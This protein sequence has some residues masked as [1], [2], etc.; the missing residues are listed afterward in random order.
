ML[1]LGLADA[2]HDAAVRSRSRLVGA[3]GLHQ[4]QQAR[5]IAEREVETDTQRLLRLR[6]AQYDNEAELW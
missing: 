1:W 4:A 6:L 5:T 2:E 3:I